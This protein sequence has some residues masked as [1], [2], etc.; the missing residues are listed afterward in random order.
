[1]TQQQ[2]LQN[3]ETLQEKQAQLVTELIAK[4]ASVQTTSRQTSRQNAKE[5]HADLVQKV[6]L[7]INT[8]KELVGVLNTIPSFDHVDEETLMKALEAKNT[9]GRGRG[10]C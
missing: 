10:S 8:V 3:N 6:V 9:N 5:S 1:M 4:I 7:E 2:Q